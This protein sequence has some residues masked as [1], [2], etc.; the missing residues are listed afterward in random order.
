[1]ASRGFCPSS[2]DLR[3]MSYVKDLLGRG[4]SDASDAPLDHAPPDPAIA[5]AAA[6]KKA[7][8]ADK[9]RQWP[10]SLVVFKRVLDKTFGDAGKRVRPFACDPLPHVVVDELPNRDLARFG[11]ARFL[12]IGQQVDAPPSSRRQLMRAVAGLFEAD[13]ADAPSESR[14]T[15]PEPLTR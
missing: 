13:V 9:T 4:A 11:L 3:R 7:T 12:L 8:N 10:K 1:M 14:L 6:K 2:K 5:S 15:L